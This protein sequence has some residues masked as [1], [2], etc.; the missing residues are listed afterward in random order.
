MLVWRT[1]AG[2][3][4]EGDRKGRISLAEKRA[5][6]MPRRKV[7]KLRVVWE[8]FCDELAVWRER[9]ATIKGDLLNVADKVC[10]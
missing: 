6:T 5:Y 4:C 8:T 9:G 3:G 7:W 10:C 2:Y 1:K